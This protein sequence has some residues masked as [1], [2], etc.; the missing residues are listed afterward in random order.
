MG[1]TCPVCGLYGQNFGDC[2]C[3]I[4]RI[5]AYENGSENENTKHSDYE[6]RCEIE[7]DC[8]DG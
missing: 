2:G 1:F 7:D 6:E 8:N 3:G 5:I 4:A